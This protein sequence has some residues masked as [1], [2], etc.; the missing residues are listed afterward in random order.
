VG[1]PNV[2]ISHSD[3]KILFACLLQSIENFNNNKS[4]AA[5]PLEAAYNL[6][7]KFDLSLDE[8]KQKEHDNNNTK[9]NTKMKMLRAFR[10]LLQDKIARIE[11]DKKLLK[12]FATE[13]L[14]DPVQRAFLLYKHS[15]ELKAYLEEKAKIKLV[16][17][18]TEKL[19]FQEITK[20]LLDAINKQPDKHVIVYYGRILRYFAEH[21]NPE[22]NF[23]DMMDF[24]KKINSR[25][26][27]QAIFVPSMGTLFLETRENLQQEELYNASSNHIAFLLNTKMHAFL[28]KSLKNDYISRQMLSFDVPAFIPIPDDPEKD[29]NKIKL[30]FKKFPSYEN[31]LNN[32]KFISSVHTVM[33]SLGSVV[34]A[35]KGS[36]SVSA[37]T[38]ICKSIDPELKFSDPAYEKKYKF[39]IIGKF[40]KEDGNPTISTENP[41]E[42]FQDPQS[43]DERISNIYYRYLGLSRTHLE[44]IAKKRNEL[45]E[46][47]AG[48]GCTVIIIDPKKIP[49]LAFAIQMRPKIL[50]TVFVT[51]NLLPKL[52]EALYEID[53]NYRDFLKGN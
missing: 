47:E 30:Y 29:F 24:T 15:K 36:Q 13:E 50:N 23:S 46:K 42:Y 34:S 31:T 28:Q 7:G 8:S 44:S 16:D 11:I 21:F 37:F 38:A 2:N 39:E 1:R 41:K 52:H 26:N 18:S 27:K 22:L 49:T 4:D 25:K 3:Y 53:K 45:K 51:S 43:D 40:Y 14:V 20:Q 9:Q 5:E 48:L 32:N 35:Q 12:R 19:L 33:F 17:A 6:Y 10:S